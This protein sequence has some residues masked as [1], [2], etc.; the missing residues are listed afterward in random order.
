MKC[1]EGING[2]SFFVNTRFAAMHDLC[3]SLTCCRVRNY[4][5]RSAVEGSTLA[6]RHAGT[7]QAKMATAI[8]S[9]NMLN[10]EFRS[11]DRIADFTA[12][13]IAAAFPRAR[14]TNESVSSAN[15]VCRVEI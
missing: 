14:I 13:T 11:T 3:A 12:G 10:H 15:Q 8:S 7:Q 4:S 2:K 9:A 6:P 5:E 1:Q